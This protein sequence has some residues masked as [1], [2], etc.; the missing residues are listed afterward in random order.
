MQGKFGRLA[1]KADGGDVVGR[2]PD[3]AFAI[4]DI[5]PRNLEEGS[6]AHPSSPYAGTTDL[7]FL[8]PSGPQGQK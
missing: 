3:G 7:P 2:A 5:R 4:G 6:A 8:S 1:G